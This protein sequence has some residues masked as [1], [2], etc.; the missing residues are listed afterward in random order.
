MS[1]LRDL[2]NQSAVVC[3][4]HILF[5]LTGGLQLVN[6]GL[7]DQGEEVHTKGVTLLSALQG[8]DEIRPCNQPGGAAIHHVH[9]P[10]QS[11]CVQDDGVKDPLSVHLIKVIPGVDE[12]RSA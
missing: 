1:Y 9:L 2:P 5:E 8:P 4:P 10:C 6:E 3:T 12:Q 7:Y 11:W